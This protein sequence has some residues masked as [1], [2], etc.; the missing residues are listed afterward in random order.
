MKDAFDLCIIGGGSSYTPELIDG[1]LQR[2]EERFPVRS[3]AMH[4]ISPERLN[5][6]AELSKRMLAHGGRRIDIRS[7]TRLEPL[8]EGVDFVIT[9]IRVG[10]MEARH[11]DETIPLKYGLIG[12]ETT[13]PGGMCKA[14]R[15]I[16]PIL[17]IAEAVADVAP[18]AFI[19]NFTN[20]SGI[21]TEA[22]LKHGRAKFIGLC[23]GIPG[24]QKSYG[25]QLKGRFPDL[26][27]Y[28]VGLNHLGFLHRMVSGGEDVTAE[29]IEEL[30]AW[31]RR[32]YPEVGD[33]S[34]LSFARKLGAI[35][36]GY[37]NYFYRT[38]EALR[39]LKEKHARGENRARAIQKLEV[40]LFREAADPTLCIKPEALKKR[41][42]SG[43]S[44]ITFDV[45]EAIWHDTGSELAVSCRNDGTVKGL[46]DD[47]AVEVVCH[48]GADG[49]TPI[50]VGPIPS[51]FRGLV[52][53]VKAFE[54]LTVAA[55]VTQSRRLALQALLTHPLVG[56]V[57]V[58]EP[59]LDEMIRAH[60]LDLA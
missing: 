36:I 8:L 45:L 29:A 11:L 56:D 20:P 47:A 10:G 21:V 33:T 52:Q 28:C 44:G 16:P 2:P 1:I 50:P 53:V 35:P 46:P 9:Q 48:V 42:G 25:E 41:G 37:L 55:A 23:S 43:Y 27:M 34:M 7:G 12:Q 26:R 30:V 49:A 38:R 57:D 17:R 24:M 14:L 54:S 4:D 60:K 13:G 3:I 59:L 40:E 15:T 58:A 22:A 31:E 39:N 5:I 32:E 51:A 18:N 19:L 6:M